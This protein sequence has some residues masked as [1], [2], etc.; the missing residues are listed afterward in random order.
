MEFYLEGSG[1]LQTSDLISKSIAFEQKNDK[2][3]TLF[4][5]KMNLAVLCVLPELESRSGEKSGDHESSPGEK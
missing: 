2:I 5:R 4:F 1:N 3:R